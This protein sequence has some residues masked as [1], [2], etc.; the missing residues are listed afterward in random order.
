MGH[1][2]EKCYKFHNLGHG[3]HKE[4]PDSIINQVAKQSQNKKKK[5][6]QRVTSQV[7]FH[8]RIS[9]TFTCSA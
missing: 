4:S 9:S 8:N 6:M 1:I 3:L 5:S 7:T 2:V